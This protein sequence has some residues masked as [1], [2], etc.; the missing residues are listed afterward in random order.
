MLSN[1]IEI[2]APRVVL[3]TIL[4]IVNSQLSAEP[5]TINSVDNV[6]KKNLQKLT[7][8]KIYICK[9]V[10]LLLKSYINTTR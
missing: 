8:P 5:Q 9:K 7:K 10:Y 1:A 6:H 2:Q 4:K 3:R